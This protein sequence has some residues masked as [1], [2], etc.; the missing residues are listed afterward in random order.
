MYIDVQSLFDL[1]NK[2]DNLFSVN[3][4]VLGVELP[5]GR[6]KLLKG[7]V[8]AVEF[9]QKANLFHHKLKAIRH[10]QRL[11]LRRHRLCEIK[12]RKDVF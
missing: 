12:M 4:P 8:V 9:A 11:L 6:D 10:R 2:L 3:F 1:L 7:Y 5:L